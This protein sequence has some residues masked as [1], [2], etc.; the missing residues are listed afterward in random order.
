[1][2]V[3]LSLGEA[4]WSPRVY[5]YTMSIAPEG[6]EATFAALAA[7]PLFAAKVPVGLMSGYLIAKYMP[8]DGHQDGQMLWLIIGL[9][10][11]TSPVLITLCER[12]I[13]EP[14]KGGTP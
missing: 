12:C 8:E 5:D 14:G 10:T 2:V 7:A 9:T 13:R 6:R 1:M 4:V 11:L 3:L